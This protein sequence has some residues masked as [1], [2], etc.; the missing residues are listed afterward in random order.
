MSLGRSQRQKIPLT[1]AHVYATVAASAARR[2][3]LDPLNVGKVLLDDGQHLNKITSMLIMRIPQ[4]IV[5]CNSETF[6]RNGRRETKPSK[7]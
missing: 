7:I 4:A 5:L 3:E 1:R 2:Y 6:N